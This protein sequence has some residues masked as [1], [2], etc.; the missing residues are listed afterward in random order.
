MN[1]KYVVMVLIATLCLASCQDKGDDPLGIKV[2]EERKQLE[3]VQREYDDKR[4]AVRMLD[5]ALEKGKTLLTAMETQL[6]QA[7]VEK[8]YADYIIIV[9]VRTRKAIV[10]GIGVKNVMATNDFPMAVS[11]KFFDA[12]EEGERI[13]FRGDGK[14]KW[15]WG[16]LNMGKYGMSEVYVKEKIVQ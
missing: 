4:R 15:D 3:L 1:R 16:P 13:D 9:E 8:G 2:I 11:K 10:P 14:F 7:K 12:L 6:T 5:A